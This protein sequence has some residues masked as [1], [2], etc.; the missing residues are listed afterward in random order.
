MNDKLHHALNEIS[1]KHLSEAENYQRSNRRPYW[2]IAAAAILGLVIGIT[3]IGPL[4]A[5]AGP[6]GPIGLN[7][8]PPFSFDE[9]ENQSTY[10]AAPEP[11]GIQSPDTLQLADLAAA[12]AYP[13][14]AQQPEQKDYPDY[15]E[16]SALVQAWKESCK[17]QYD[18]P[19]GY[20]DSLTDFFTQSIPQFLDP[21]ENSSYSPVNAYMALAMLA[22]TT[23][24]NSRQQILDALGLDTIEQLREQVSHV[25]NAHYSDDGVTT[26]LLG[27]SLWLSDRFSF[28]QECLDTL[29]STH[30][31]SSF[32]GT[33]GTESFNEQLR[34]WINANT[35]NLLSAQA[36][37][38]EMS[39]RTAF[40]LASTVYFS[41]DWENGFLDRLT[42]DKVF[43]C[44]G[45][46]T[47]A[48]FMKDTFYGTYYRGENFGAV[49]L[50][51]TGENSMWLIL[52]D[53]G[54]S[55]AD[56]LESDEYLRLAMDPLR[57]ENKDGYIK[58]HLQLPKFDVS[59]NLDLK[60][61]LK[62]MGI[63]DV[64]NPTVSDFSPITSQPELFVNK[65][66]HA[67][68]VVIDE[69]GCVAAAF[70]V[71]YAYAGSAFTPPE[72][73]I[74]FVLDRPFLFVI[75]SRDHLPLFVST[76]AEP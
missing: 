11:S 15:D 44:D 21:S 2:I 17:N 35:G 18:Q 6:T 50:D 9:P 63:T 25:W 58:I 57:W 27:N 32:H 4:T 75:S 38:L 41:A 70:T 61:G 55:V 60:D 34:Q 69:E 59:S 8:L 66:D 56:I 71:T 37:K 12:P 52:P 43:H 22:E 72:K 23:D 31:A 68:R 49:E 10:P 62:E 33:M 51:M 28:H 73:E 7:T 46:D 67:A 53:E 76:V 40:A 20:A 36:E 5:P 45:Y 26:L 16:Y 54:Y 14:M 13:Q 3:A 42:E 64:F 29:A 74:H 48:A 1:D 19:D 39:D 24:G 65:I 30:Y 47:T